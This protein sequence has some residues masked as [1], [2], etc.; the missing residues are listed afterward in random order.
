MITRLL[1]KNISVIGAY[2]RLTNHLKHAKI[3]VVKKA[4]NALKTSLE[5]PYET[6]GYSW[7]TVGR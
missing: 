2:L 3:T 7:Y 5:K 4:L 6:I 1:E